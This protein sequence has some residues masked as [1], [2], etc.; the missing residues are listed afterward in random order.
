MVEVIDSILIKNL[1]PQRKNY[2]VKEMS[3][4][5]IIKTNKMELY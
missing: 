3:G 5:Y 1:D 4:N 2:S